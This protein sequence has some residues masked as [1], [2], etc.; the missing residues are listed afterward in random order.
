VVGID[1][2][3]KRGGRGKAAGILQNPRSGLMV[4][5]L[6]A[7]LLGTAP[8]VHHHVATRTAAPAAPAQ[9]PTGANAGKPA[10]L[11]GCAHGAE[12]AAGTG[13]PAAVTGRARG[14]DV[15]PDTGAVVQ[16]V[17]ACRHAA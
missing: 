7:F 17:V 15:G 5:V 10:A 3:R 9:P 12:V 1:R 2:S 4:L 8:A 13:K 11:T 14:A 6:L 16:L